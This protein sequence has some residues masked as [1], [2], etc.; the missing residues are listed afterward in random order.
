MIVIKFLG[1][2][3]RA[4]NLVKGTEVLQYTE[5]VKRAYPD[6]REENISPKEVKASNVKK[7][8]TGDF[9]KGLFPDEEFSLFFY[10]MPD[11]SKLFESRQSADFIPNSV[12]A[13]ALIDGNGKFLKESLWTEDDIKKF[14]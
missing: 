2:N 7:K 12:I 1:L 8:N 5:Y 13:L 9:I 3:G 14:R 4:M 6:G 10:E 11:G